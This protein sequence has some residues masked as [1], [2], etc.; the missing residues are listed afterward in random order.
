MMNE[1]SE[2]FSTELATSVKPL[3]R[4]MGMVSIV[5]DAVGAEWRVAIDQSMSREA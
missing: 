5:L 2:S 4:P 3:L 1:S